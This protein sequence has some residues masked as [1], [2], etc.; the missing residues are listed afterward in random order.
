MVSIDIHTTTG[1]TECGNI[2][3]RC[4][5]ISSDARTLH[6]FMRMILCSGQGNVNCKLY[7]WGRDYSSSPLHCSIPMIVPVHRIHIPSGERA[8][9]LLHKICLWFKLRNDPSELHVV[10][11]VS[12]DF[13]V[14]LYWQ[15]RKSLGTLR[16]MPRRQIAV[17][18]PQYFSITKSVATN[19]NCLRCSM[20]FLSLCR[21]RGNKKLPDPYTSRSS[22]QCHN[23]Y[24]T[25]ICTGRCIH[26]SGAKYHSSTVSFHELHLQQ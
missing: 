20:A 11:S 19:M 13:P 14:P 10:V 3:F 5:V 12:T 23:I 25:I 15:V 22:E 21:H 8:R 26:R 9:Q 24:P 18:L 6:A 1:S 4:N 7:V 2:N 17:S 16:G